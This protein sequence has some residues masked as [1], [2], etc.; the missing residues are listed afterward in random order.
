MCLSR[1]YFGYFKVVG[2]LDKEPSRFWC[3]VKVQKHRRESIVHLAEIT[4][5]MLLAYNDH[6]KQKP[7]RILVCVVWWLFFDDVCFWHTDYRFYIY[8][9]LLLCRCIVMGL[10]KGILK[11]LVKI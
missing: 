1:H 8:F 4:K 5:E 7:E 2:N 6:V 9:D 3:R 10:A 11:R